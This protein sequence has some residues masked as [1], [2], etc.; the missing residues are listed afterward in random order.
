MQRK[1]YSRILCSDT[2]KK[3]VL[4]F[5]GRLGVFYVHGD[6]TIIT[7]NLFTVFNC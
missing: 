7:E 5:L 3:V 1:L 2:V 4:P 6:S